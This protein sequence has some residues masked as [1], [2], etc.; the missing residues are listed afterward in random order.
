MA[1]VEDWDNFGPLYVYR[2]FLN[3]LR[4][5]IV[6]R[7]LDFDP[8][9]PTT[10]GDTKKKTMA[11]EIGP[12]TDP[13]NMDVVGE[14]IRNFY[15]DFQDLMTETLNTASSPSYLQYW[16]EVNWDGLVATSLPLINEAV[17]L[18]RIGDLSRLD[19]PNPLDT[20]T[21]IPWMLQQY[22]MLNEL[23]WLELGFGVGSNNPT[24]NIRRGTGFD[25]NYATAVAE[26]EA[27]FAAGTN[28]ATGGGAPE[29]TTRVTL[30][31]GNY[32]VLYE[33]KIN[34]WD[35]DTYDG[36]TCDLDTYLYPEQKSVFTFEDFG[37]GLTED[38][39]NYI[40]T[41]SSVGGGG[42]GFGTST[43]YVLYEPTTGFAGRLAPPAPGAPGT[44]GL[45]WTMSNAQ[46]LASATAV[47]KFNVVGG[48]SK[49]N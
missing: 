40:Q 8:D 11:T 29:N 35:T 12:L 39:M 20:D 10:T 7:L 36:Y 27:E 4:V 43:H 9:D 17:M 6:E 15:D 25:S 30:A 45:A 34:N 26:A 44:N 13:A 19:A 37:L 41:D 49:I 47:L 21:I 5:G 16:D 1:W 32:T 23:R 48:F 42:P 3:E 24:D 2:P 22:E 28:T 38:A 46:G 31:A 18:T 14:G 33:I